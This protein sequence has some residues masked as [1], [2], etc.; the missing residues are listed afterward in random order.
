MRAVQ[1][2][3]LLR[4][5]RDNELGRFI[6]VRDAYG[7]IYIYGDLGTVAA[8]L[9]K[10]S[11]VPA[12]A[13][14]GSL[15]SGPAGGQAKLLLEIKPAGAEA[16]DP[17]PLIEAWQL[18]EVTQAQ[19]R[20]N[21][22]PLFG[23]TA[24]DALVNEVLLMSATQLQTHLLAEPRLHLDACERHAISSGDI[25]RRVLA[26]LE[27]LLDSGLA[28]S[29]SSS[30]CQA[31]APGAPTRDLVISALDG[32]P[33]GAGARSGALT[34]LAL[35]R[36][37]AL[38]GA[39]KPQRIAAPIEQHGADGTRV[40]RG[41]HN[42]I[43]VSFGA[44]APSAG[45][46]GASGASGA[47]AR[48]GNK[49]AGVVA[50]QN[51]AGIAAT[52]SAAPLSTGEWRKLLARIAQVPE[53]H[54]STAPT[55]SSVPDTAASP[56]PSA[57]GGS[58]FA[59]VAGTERAAPEPESSEQTRT[60]SP[61]ATSG[62]ARSLRLSA[63]LLGAIPSDTQAGEC[64][65]GIEDVTLE[66]AHVEGEPEPTLLEGLVT[67]KA[68]I[69]ST[70]G[71]VEASSFQDSA[72][73]EEKWNPLNVSGSSEST[74]GSETTLE[75]EFESREDANG[76]Y[77]LCVA[78]TIGGVKHVGLLDDRL[79]AN[80]A[81]VAQM[82][83]PHSPAGA[84]AAASGSVPLEAAVEKGEGASLPPVSFQYKPSTPRNAPSAWQTIAEGVDAQ[85]SVSTAGGIR[86]V[87][88]GFNT[89]ALADGEY[90]FR[91]IPSQAGS[92]LIPAPA[93]R[94]TVDNT[95]PQIVETTLPSSLSGDVTLTATAADPVPAPP[96][97]LGCE[98]EGA[99]V[100]SVTFERAAQGSSAFVAVGAPV[101]N[102]S[103]T[104]LVPVSVPASCKPTSKGEPE[105]DGY[106][107]DTY[108]LLVHSEAIPNG[109]YEFRLTVVDRAGN[110]S[111]ETIGGIEI[112]N[113]PSP[114]VNDRVN[115][116]TLPAERV[117]MLG[118]IRG[119][120]SEAEQ[121]GASEQETWA[122][123]YASGPPA[124]GLNGQPLEYEE[125][126]DQ[127][128]LLRYTR[129][130]GWQI[131][132]VLRRQGKAFEM[133]HHESEVGAIEVR[134]AMSPSGEAWMWFGEKQAKTGKLISGIF[135]RKAPTKWDEYQPFEYDAEASTGSIGSALDEWSQGPVA[136][137]L[138]VSFHLGEAEGHPYGTVT[139]PGQTA[140]PLTVPNPTGSGTIAIK[141][142]LSYWELDGGEWE[143]RAAPVPEAAEMPRSSP[144]LVPGNTVTL[145]AA[146]PTGPEAGW[147][148][149]AVE[150]VT[151]PLPGWG[152][153]LGRLEPGSGAPRWSF[154]PTGLDALDLSEA[155]AGTGATVEEESLASEGDAV[156][157]GAGVAVPEPA[158][159]TGG[160]TRE[161]K[162]QV[163][164]RY[165]RASG[166]TGRLLNSAC[167][168]QLGLHAEALENHCE[169]PLGDAAVPEA[170]FPAE[171]AAI[172]VSGGMVHVF[173][174]ERWSAAPAS[175]YVGT[176]ES[177]SRNEGGAAFTDA[178]DGWLAGTHAL[179]HWSPEGNAGSLNSWPVPD[180][181]TLTSVAV[182]PAAGIPP[183]GPALIG[184]PG[185][186]AVG[187]HGTSLSYE[188]SLGWL[189]Q[190]VPPF[191]RT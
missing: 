71:T 64:S 77:D 80:R 43:D 2:S 40:A 13:V 53:P 124:S 137:P 134:G 128:V 11:W 146:D 38:P 88:P 9:H 143:K 171:K 72:A 170:F 6:E 87:L 42:A 157:V 3:Q 127:L 90:D 34:E 123:G 65:S 63:P 52:P 167:S 138:R 60:P 161:V 180:Q 74:T 47:G 101:R 98:T 35:Q 129:A 103:S 7:D 175:G 154:A 75:A 81:P 166:S 144:G 153:I 130:T 93:R 159:E 185:A 44:Q 31:A 122:Y 95:A 148:A 48:S 114:P 73:E 106:E 50:A 126:G 92:E 169:E 182:P 28:P 32:T 145:T 105:H 62:S 121:K 79:I 17:R 45:T 140:A 173:S 83:A 188:T 108:P 69:A 58:P 152:F 162:V 56:A 149:L 30:S 21:T 70:A 20:P 37:L 66:V 186:L 23:A 155:F 12:A 29:V 179:G 119:G 55:S 99:G 165:E 156:W 14:I 168:E 136:H 107:K 19:P 187:L 178:R 24:R 172:G 183:G 160:L 120:A 163:V 26:T 94:V 113:E 115:G 82:L 96:R 1:Q 51:P 41:P 125:Q 36:L 57:A 190:P 27:L 76:D 116:V 67:L 147:G 132:D 111:S 181:F 117:T 86:Y 151:S 33:V 150:D 97:S 189:A 59:P 18:L 68:R 112:H 91:A 164:A 46:T 135:R 109:T 110:R 102:P 61:P 139:A 39:L 54:V 78:L 104:Q 118:A 15:P 141:G 177:F 84:H 131:A 49:P 191:A 100:K 10:G 5:G 25:D 8:S 85:G 16:I 142:K 158:L 133:F 176:Q 89:G 4:V 184:E 22:Q 174:H